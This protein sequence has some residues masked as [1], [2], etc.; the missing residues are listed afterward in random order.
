MI[1]K[2]LQEKGIDFIESSDKIKSK[3]RKIENELMN[4]PKVVRRKK[5]ISLTA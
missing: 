5:E 4:A 1:K 2:Q 3:A